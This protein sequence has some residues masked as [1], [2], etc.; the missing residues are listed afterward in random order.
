MTWFMKNI[1]DQSES[2]KT[3]F[4]SIFVKFTSKTGYKQKN[5]QDWGRRGLARVG[6]IVFLVT[7]PSVQKGNQIYMLQRRKQETNG[8]T[9]SFYTPWTARSTTKRYC[10]QWPKATS[11]W[12]SLFYMYKKFMTDIHVVCSFCLYLWHNFYI[13]LLTNLSST[14]KCTF[15]FRIECCRLIQILH[16]VPQNSECIYQ[17]HEP[18]KFAGSHHYFF[19]STFSP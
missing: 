18:A 15:M 8:S 6:G 3:Y 17:S 9:T 5:G 4:R 10:S 7:N 14:L 19:K 13:S 2:S 12:F 16:N 11:S 1:N